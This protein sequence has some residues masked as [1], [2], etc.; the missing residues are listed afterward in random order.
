MTQVPVLIVL[1]LTLIANEA[2][3]YNR[4]GAG[5]A[6]C[7]IWAAFRREGTTSARALSSEQWVLGFIDGITEA[8]GGSLDPLNGMEAENVWEWIDNY[9]QTNPLKSVAEAGS[10]FIAAH[11]R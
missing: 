11:P 6:S 1:A 7:G 9:C 5:T 8:S 2:A 4:L 10:A 3:G